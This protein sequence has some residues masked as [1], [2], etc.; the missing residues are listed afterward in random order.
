M[1]YFPVRYN[2]RVVIYKREI[3]IRLATE[4][5]TSANLINIFTTI[6]YDQ[7]VVI[8]VTFLSVLH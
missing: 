8:W 1:G 3:F 4:D 5:S 2:S 6:N 7:R